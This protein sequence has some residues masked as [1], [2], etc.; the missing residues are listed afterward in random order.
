MEDIRG[1]FV[2]D[3]TLVPNQEALSS[4]LLIHLQYTD[5][6]NSLSSVAPMSMLEL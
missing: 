2:T 4:Q 6:K 1:L 3:S 5:H